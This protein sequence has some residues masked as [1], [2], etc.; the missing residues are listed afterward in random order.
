M[1]YY[2]LEKSFNII[3]H[4]GVGREN[5]QWQPFGKLPRKIKFRLSW[6]QGMSWRGHIL[7]NE[8]KNTS[9]EHW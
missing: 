3:T 7:S 8:S 6:T 5:P 1:N 4:S 9:I 2:A